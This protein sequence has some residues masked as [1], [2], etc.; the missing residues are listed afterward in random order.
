M[1]KQP[2]FWWLAWILLGPMAGGELQTA[3]ISK[4]PLTWV[5]LPEFR[6]QICSLLWK[7]GAVPCRALQHTGSFLSP[8]VSVLGLPSSPQPQTF[9][10]LTATGDNRDEQG[11]PSMKEPNK[12]CLIPK[13]LVL[14]P[15]EMTKSPHFKSTN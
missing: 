11:L 3:K 4:D 6:K 5:S 10:C 7:E 2:T 15:L 8:E 12:P 14:S 13:N 1:R 9:C